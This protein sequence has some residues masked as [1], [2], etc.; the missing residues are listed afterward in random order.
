MKTFSINLSSHSSSWL[1]STNHKYIGILPLSCN[2]GYHFSPTNSR[3]NQYLSRRYTHNTRGVFSRIMN[4]FTNSIPRQS[5]SSGI[6]TRASLRSS[7]G[8]NQNEFSGVSKTPLGTFDRSLSTIAKSSISRFPNATREFDH[9]LRDDTFFQ[10]LMTLANTPL[11]LHTKDDRV[12][13]QELLYL[14]LRNKSFN[15]RY[16]QL[17][18]ERLFQ[19]KKFDLEAVLDAVP[20]NFTLIDLFNLN[21][22][23]VHQST[24]F[25][26]FQC[27]QLADQPGFSNKIESNIIIQTPLKELDPQKMDSVSR[28]FILYSQRSTGNTSSDLQLNDHPYDFKFTNDQTVPLARNVIVPIQVY[29]EEALNR[30]IGTWLF[31]LKSVD[32]QYPNINENSLNY[33]K[34]LFEK[35]KAIHGNT[36]LDPGEKII[37]INKITFKDLDSR[38][39]DCFIP[40]VVPVGNKSCLPDTSVTEKLNLPP[41][42]DTKPQI[43]D[44]KYN[45]LIEQFESKNKE[46]LFIR[47]KG[48]FGS[49][50][51]NSSSDESDSFSQ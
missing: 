18:L 7:V 39:S 43:V 49:L 5:I 14:F 51:S 23:L 8:L 48:L 15:N 21:G 28:K 26:A 2:T 1:F 38:P 13:I 9:F 4:G 24:L 41:T 45:L 6:S 44:Q 27:H 12:L 36:S 33:Y 19:S 47:T 35:A 16:F 17:S 3:T 46:L 42:K 32:R 50:S 10:V 25:T 20:E 29:N 37:E 31:H 34:A 30:F 22:N 11:H 40:I